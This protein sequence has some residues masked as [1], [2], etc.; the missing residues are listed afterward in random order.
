L[1]AQFP[2][3]YG[4]AINLN[5]AKTLRLALLTLMLGPTDD[6]IA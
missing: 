1:T 2:S 4:L 5:T 6:V 3:K